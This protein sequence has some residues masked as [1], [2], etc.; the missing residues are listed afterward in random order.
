MEEKE[1]Q[2]NGM[3]DIDVKNLQFKK[4]KEKVSDYQKNYVILSEKGKPT[5]HLE[6]VYLPFGAE[7]YNKKYILNIEMYPTKN[8]VHNNLQSLLLALEQEFSDKLIKS[9][10]LSQ[11]IK[12]LTY[13]SFLKLNS[14]KSIHLRTYMSPNPEIYTY[15]GK[16]KENILQSS[17]Q[18]TTC[19]IDLELGTLWM[20]G[21]NYG[22]I[23]YVKSVCIL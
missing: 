10:E 3:F 4:T 23:W 12:D 1:D 5:I 11:D 6:K 17:L 22:V 15:V 7:Y 18:G 19:N 16:F 13:H 21:V 9:Y 14:N 8:N 2:L 20:N